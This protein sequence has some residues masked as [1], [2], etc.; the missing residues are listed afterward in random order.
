M[1]RTLNRLGELVGT[2]RGAGLLVGVTLLTLFAVR[3]LLFPGMGGDEGEQLVFSQYFDWGYQVRNPPL[4]TWLVIAI[5]KAI[6]TNVYSVITI[7]FAALILSYFFLWKSAQIILDDDRLAALVAVSPLALYY[8]AWDS[9]YGYSHSVLVMAF[10]M[11]TLWLVVRIAEIP[12][13]RDFIWLGLVIGGGL[14]SKYVFVLFL[15]ALLSAIALDRSFRQNLFRPPLL[16]SLVIA[17]L[18][19]MPHLV[20]LVQNVENPTG[21]T[22]DSNSI[23]SLLRLLLAIVGF[24]SPLW[25]ILVILFPTAVK[26]R[27]ISSDRRWARLLELYFL[28]L[29]G[30]AVIA[31]LTLQMDRLRTHYLFILLP[32][33][34]YF[35]LRIKT[36]IAPLP[37]LQLYGGIITVF[38]AVSALGM[39]I[40]FAGEPLKCSRCQH[41]IPYADLANELSG[42]G[43]DRGTIFAYW[44]PDP[45][46]GNLRVWFTDS[47]VISAK[48][49]KV[50]P[51]LND[52]KGQCLLVWPLTNN[53]VGRGATIAMANRY[54]GTSIAENT[55]GRQV[56]APLVMGNGKRTGLGYILIEPGQGTCR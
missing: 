12:R 13:T 3:G 27:P 47:R 8:V 29:C 35:F 15:V 19:L 34:I 21:G 20:W 24:L 2:G 25:L 7:K 41:H 22:V 56:D 26:T 10:Y 49:P 1:N 4:F 37:R 31:I 33:I 52:R 45:I 6:G 18:V 5:S 54:L 44:H 11:A 17:T 23:K 32:M 42:A 51:P 30:A 53:D 48:H 16:M 55:P 50:Q 14:L 40:K 38:A 43:F 28:I 39:M 9:I 36:V 46:A